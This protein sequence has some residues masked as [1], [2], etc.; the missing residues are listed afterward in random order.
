MT[1]NPNPARAALDAEVLDWIQEDKWVRDDERF[2]SLARRLFCHQF[3]QC[4]PYARFAEGR[5]ITPGSLTSWNEIP[6]VP[7]AAFKE[8]PLRSFPESQTMVTLRT[9]GT[10]GSRRGE[11]H[12]DTLAVYQASALASLR[13]HL[14][15]DLDPGQAIIRVLAPSSEEVPD[16]SLSLMFE[17]LIEDSGGEMNSFDIRDGVIEL[18]SLK[19]GIESSISENRPLVLCGTAFA[20]VH[21][22]D[23]LSRQGTRFSCPPGSRIMETGGFKGRS[24]ELSR[25]DLHSSLSEALGIKPE[26]IINQYGMTELGSQFYDSTLIDPVGPRRKLIPP[27]VAVRMLDP[28]TSEEVAPGEPGMIT[29]LDL[30]NTGSIASIQ[31]ADLGRQ[32]QGDPSGFEVLGR[33]EGAEERGCSIAADE[34]L[35]H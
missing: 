12:L 10:S 22:L 29:L 15:V 11:L 31:T 1:W 14:L 7:A 4:L 17:F 21:L 3:E 6:A 23:E 30:A 26:S 33:Q 8:M 13:R 25:V 34:M 32:I 16:S 27:W 5:G 24:R 28:D 18:E 19:A 2:D 20:F 35:G 9:S